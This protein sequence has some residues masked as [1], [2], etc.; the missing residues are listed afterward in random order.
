MRQKEAELSE[1]RQP[2]AGSLS[3]TAVAAAP[4]CEAR[5]GKGTAPD[6]AAAMTNGTEQ[7]Q[8]DADS[9]SASFARSP[10][11][12]F[13]VIAEADRTSRAVAGGRDAFI[14]EKLQAYIGDWRKDPNALPR[15]EIARKLTDA[16]LETTREATRRRR[17]ARLFSVLIAA[18]A[19]MVIAWLR[20][21]PTP[22][23]FVIC[24][25][26]GAI[27]LLL[28]PFTVIVPLILAWK[29]ETDGFRVVIGYFANGL[30]GLNEKVDSVT[31]P[32]LGS[33]VAHIIHPA[34]GSQ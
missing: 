32:E 15:V 7:H 23:E 6:T 5:L 18:L 31:C 28:L 24:L 21:S 13:S 30:P 19:T 9:T 10:S 27:A 33:R 14:I 8:S 29:C 16:Y 20:S 2:D 4:A 17:L 12:I 3:G 11:Q 1:L 26:L 34:G 22:L 25:F